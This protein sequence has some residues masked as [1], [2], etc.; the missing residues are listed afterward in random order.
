LTPE[1]W[2]E[3]KKVLAGALERTPPERH[4]Y[5]DQAC[6]DASLRRE[7]ESL[8]AAHEQ[9][10]S[11]FIERPVAGS[12]EMLKSGTKLGPYEIVARVGAGGMGVVYKAEDTR[13]GRIVAIKVLPVH[14][15]DRSESR[16]RF[17]REARTVASLNH[18]HICILYDVGHQD[19]TDYLVMEYLEGETLAQRLIK[20]PLPLNQ[21]LQYAT[22]IADALDK[23]H[24]KGVTHRDLKPGNVML[25]Q[26]GAK[27]LD[28]GL[29]KLKRG[30][31]GLGTPLSQLPTAKASI[32]AEG[33]IVGTLQYMAP[34]QLEGKETDART[35]IF[36][37]GAV[38]YEMA[39]GEKAFES[40]SQASLI[41]KILETHPPPISSIQPMTPPALDRLVK[42]CLVKD[43]DERWQ[44]ASDLA[45]EL[46]WIADSGS[47]AGI[48]API[49]ARR[50]W[51]A[52]IA[53]ALVLAALGGGW[54]VSRFRQPAADANVLRVSINP[55]EGGA[56]FFGTA[57]GGIA[58]S[59]DGKTAAFVATVSGETAL[60][61]RPLNETG[62]HMLP[63]T[64]GAYYPFWS[65]DSKSVA[66]F[67][68][69]NK[70]QSIEVEG[71]T[72]STICDVSGG[73][74]GSGGRGGAWTSDG[75]IIFGVFGAGLFRA[76]ASGG[77]PSPL[78]TLDSSHGELDHRWPQLLP[79]GRLLFW[80][81]SDKTENTGV[82]AASLAKPSERVRLLTTDTGALYVP[83]NDGKNYLVW[84]REGKLVAQEFDPDTLKL[85][86]EFRTISDQVAASAPIG[87]MI[88][89]ASVNGLLL[90]S[91][92]NTVSQ[93]TWFDR[94]GK[95]LGTLGEP[96]GY[97][98][99]RLS[100]D[101]RGVVAA[102]DKPGGTDLW[103]LETERGLANRFTFRPGNNNYPIWS[104]NSGTVVFRSLFSMVRKEA[105]GTGDVDRLTE[106]TNNQYPSDW[107][108]DGR[109]ILYF[110]NAPST[111]GWDLWAL[112]VTPNGKPEAKP[113]P[114]L[115]TQ[116][117]ERHGRFAPE[118]NP[119][120]V[121]YQSDE[122]GR[123]EVY[124]DGFPEPRHKV[125]VSTGGGEYPEWSPAGREL[126]YVSPDLKLMAVSLKIGGDS[127]A[128][129]APREL[130]ALP[131]FENGY[132]LYAVGH[133]GQRFLVLA[134]P[135][136]QD[137]QPL[138]LISN[139]PALLTG[140]NK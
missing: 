74:G 108:R 29:A 97:E 90:F 125:R 89:A 25:T 101:G 49:P 135:E 80:V 94:A 31:S 27:L 11:D 102:R 6:P 121:A 9:G 77:A 55:P 7:V 21:V 105:T 129:S 86:G 100:P 56:F 96:G 70:L 4:S 84:Q 133:D 85:L 138:T 10:H 112:P 42:T 111:T 107:S 109:W 1:R 44:S 83:G 26:S 50:W 45:R 68:E 120:W 58:L 39:T 128:T 106:S 137:P 123:D 66:F 95:R 126:F 22:E 81:R 3:I 28:F 12:N 91:S 82:Y 132:E 140:S 34:E 57:L 30:A 72:P 110:E 47:Q 17:E 119:G 51:I 2:Q 24:R 76:P 43:P 87:H 54:I 60:W 139:W 93:F 130:F 53:A 23:A 18:P 19:G 136:R 13:L 8:I 37:L 114:Y 65:P 63:G 71:G 16:E 48:A 115:H 64:D 103:L 15:A 131:V 59:P 75:Q 40:K 61:V 122:S 35:D 88:A 78:T 116:F 92:A 117:N 73:S 5:L 113:R 38:V 124:I 46:R 62:A 79:G 67:A 99:F 98:N 14:L 69:N 20:G 41:A 104:P 32:T 118:P 36:A 33:A 52:W 134:L 127:V